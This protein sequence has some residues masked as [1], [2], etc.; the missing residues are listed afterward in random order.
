MV[1]DRTRLKQVLI[2]LLSNAI[3]Y[4]ARTAVVEVAAIGGRAHAP[5]GARHAAPACARTAGCAVPALQPIG[6]GSRR[7]EG[8]GIGLVVTKGLVELMGGRI[9]VDSVLGQGSTFWIELPAAPDLPAAASARRVFP[10]RRGRDEAAVAA[11]AVTVLCVDDDLP[12][13]RLIE[14]ML[15]AR[16]GTQVLTATNGRIGVELARRHLPTVIVMDN[17][18]P[19]MTGREARALLRADPATARIP[20]IALSATMPA[21]PMRPRVARAASAPFPSRSRWIWC[22]TRSTRRSRRRCARMR[23]RAGWPKAS[24]A[25]LRVAP[26]D[27]PAASG[28]DQASSSAQSQVPPHAGQAQRAQWAACAS[29]SAAS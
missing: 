7:A 2:N 25:V 1:A 9:G 12:S 20:I 24:P 18:M 11:P 23:R 10:L 6:P 8:S 5:V 17:N 15:A 13:L 14:D 3:K 28:A 19:E 29:A 4:N 26:C 21:A 16:P 22:W 27:H